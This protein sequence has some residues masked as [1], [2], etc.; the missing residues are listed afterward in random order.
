MQRKISGF[1]EDYI[2]GS[3]YSDSAKTGGYEKSSKHRKAEE[4][5]D[6]GV[7]LRILSEADFIEICNHEDSSLNLEE[8]SQL[9][10]ENGEET[11]S[12]ADNEEIQLSE[13][14]VDISEFFKEIQVAQANIREISHSEKR[15]FSIDIMDSVQALVKSLGS[16]ES[17]ITDEEYDEV[18]YM[19]SELDLHCE[20]LYWV[21]KNNISMSEYFEELKSLIDFFE[22]EVEEGEY[23]QKSLA[24]IKQVIV[25]FKDVSK[26]LELL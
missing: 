21:M 26:D 1:K 17:E 15:N 12:P 7:D 3:W 2:T 10:Q 8:P 23:G 5:I 6:E 18:D 14:D 25:L 13:N 24:I 22:L 9:I 20:T 19:I 4:L 16:L 11:K